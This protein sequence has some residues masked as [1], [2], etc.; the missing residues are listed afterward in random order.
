MKKLVRIP[1]FMVI[2]FSAFVLFADPARAYAVDGPCFKYTYP[3]GH[4]DTVAYRF[5]QKFDL[6]RDGRSFS[7]GPEV[8]PYEVRKA[9]EAFRNGV[10]YNNE[11]SL[12]TVIKYPLVVHVS[13]SLDLNAKTQDLTIHDPTEWLSFQKKYFSKL[14]VAMVACAYLGNVSAMTGRS[15]GV[16]IGDGTFWFKAFVGDPTVRLI[17]VNLGPLDTK[18]LADSCTP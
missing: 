3:K 9:L 4:S 15:P 2:V 11:S 18:S 16:M 17:T 10:L 5:D 14:H 1:M 8:R 7:C 13:Q 12:K 6:D